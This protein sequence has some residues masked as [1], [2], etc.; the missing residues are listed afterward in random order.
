MFNLIGVIE[1]G[2]TNVPC[3]SLSPAPGTNVCKQPLEPSAQKSGAAQCQT[4]W[5][6]AADIKSGKAA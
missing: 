5:H 6:P 3:H 1:Y 2:D 4:S